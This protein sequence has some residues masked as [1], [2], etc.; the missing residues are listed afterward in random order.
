MYV[1]T[2]RGSA[3]KTI[4]KG[5]SYRSKRFL[6]E[7]FTQVL[8]GAQPSSLWHSNHRC[9]PSVPL[10]PLPTAGFSRVPFRSIHRVENNA[11]GWEF[12]SP[13]HSRYAVQLLYSGEC[14]HAATE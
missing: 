3:F 5:F 8:L 12:F 9:F 10:A 6:G 4:F 11:R 13:D 1:S 2:I 7:R 14:F